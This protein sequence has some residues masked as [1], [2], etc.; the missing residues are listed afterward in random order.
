MLALALIMACQ[1][2]SPPAD[3]DKWY[4]RSGY[5]DFGTSVAAAG[6][7]DRD[8]VPDWI[9]ADGGHAKDGIG[10]RLWI[11][12]G[13]DAAVIRSVALPSI[14]E[15]ELIRLDGGH[16]VDADGVPDVLVAVTARH[17]TNGESSVH[18]V[19]GA[20]GQ[21]LRTLPARTSWR[22]HGDW[23]TFVPD[24]DDDG[25]W[26]VA[27]LSREEDAKHC[28]LVVHSGRTG[29][30]LSTTKLESVCGESASGMAWVDAESEG[31][32]R[33]AVLLSGVGVGSPSVQLVDGKSSK[34]VWLAADFPEPAS[35]CFGQL[36]QLRV[37]N[38]SS[39]LAAG[40]GDGVDLLDA[41]TGR[42]IHRLT[43]R[44]KTDREM[45]Y[46]WDLAS[47]GDID[48]D[49][50]ADL[51]LSETGSGLSEGIVRAFSGKSGKQLW[52]TSSNAADVYRLGY[53]LACVGDIDGDGIADL[54]AGTW[55]G[56]AGVPGRAFV[57]SGKTGQIVREVRRDGDSV[58]T[59]VS[60]ESVS[61]PR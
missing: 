5:C 31:L 10:A 14:R 2:P 9:V 48:V 61:Q 41:A 47:L 43:P 38:G 4:V 7:A 11:L 24:A 3:S 60:H 25:S 54:V 46:G 30:A 6:D 42:R 1:A 44:G 8:G 12:S 36:I 29:A 57:L 39:I 45:G 23:A 32:R 18:V 52:A 35:G 20:S 40:Y 34:P 37:A 17:D 50:T 28:T 22:D 56:K 59:V 16:D 58:T 33:Y 27:V 49:G 51:A 53:S 19:S 15:G 55:G 13:K 26:D 21:I